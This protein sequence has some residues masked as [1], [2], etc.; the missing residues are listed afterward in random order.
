MGF[1]KK[2]KG[3]FSKNNTEAEQKADTEELTREIEDIK[4]MLYDNLYKWEDV[5]VMECLTKKTDKKRLLIIDDYNAIT[6]IVKDDLELILNKKINKKL[7][8]ETIKRIESLDLSEDD[9]EI[10]AVSS[11]LAP[12]I[13]YKSCMNTKCYFDYAIIDILYGDFIVKD[14]KK[15]YL[16]GIDI[17]NIL[18]KNNPDAK[19]VLFT[20]CYLDNFY[21]KERESII[22][23]LGEDYLR[24]NIMSKT[25][26]IDN[27]ISFFIDRLFYKDMENS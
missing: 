17:V 26:E 22:K 20:G 10:C 15:L 21:N 23:N 9:I 8:A 7:S 4:S 14:G 2:I 24:N 13:V 16:D 12:Y 18:V 11:E 6:N 1:L 5:P 3:M 25:E 19:T 27:R